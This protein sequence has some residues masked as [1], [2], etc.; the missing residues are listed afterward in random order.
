MPSSFLRSLVWAPTIAL[1]WLWGLGFFYAI[2]VTLTYGW[3]G[4]IAFAV[5]NATGLFLFGWILNS[6]RREPEQILSKAG[7]QYTLLFL[8]CQIFAVA[9]TIFGFAS[10]LWIPLFGEHSGVVVALL[11]LLSCAVGHA[12]P[13]A[14][15]R[16]LH[17]AYL[18]LGVAAGLLALWALRAAPV[19]PPLPLA[20]FDARFYGLVLPTLVGFLLGPW[21]D[22]Q[23]WQRVVEIRRAG[24][25]AG[26]AY[27]AGALLFLGLLALN[28]ALAA[29]AGRG[30]V[31]ITADGLPAAQAA[32]ALAIRAAHLDLA[33]I[34]FTIWA[35][36]A[37][38]ST[39]DSAYCATRWLMS[40]ITTRSTAPLMAFVP[41]GLVSS[42]VSLMLA[43]GGIAI[44]MVS[45]DL[46]L[47]Y[48]MI[49]FATLLVGSAACLVCTAFG[50]TQRH[51][52]VLNLMIGLA[53]AIVFLAGYV[54]PV[55]VFLTLAPLI[56]LIGA[57]PLL[58][59]RLGWRAK[60]PPPEA[61]IEAG[62]TR[63]VATVHPMPRP[64]S[65]ASHG[66]DGEWFVL[67]MTPTYDDTN[68]VGNIY[69]ANYFR[70]VGKARELFFN[71]C[72]PDFDLSRTDFYILTR[73]FTHDFR[74][75]A[76]EFD[77]VTV[78]IKVAEHNRKFVTLAHEIHSDT[79]GLLGRGEQTLMFVDPRSYR[80]LDIPRV[81]LE[82][83][84]PYLPATSAYVARRA[85]ALAEGQTVRAIG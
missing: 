54:A 8:L 38:V 45:N 25:S 85:A 39:I 46:S 69:F 70:W 30:H 21:M 41:E 44:A 61:A 79:H 16:L 11:L 36:I 35:A 83:F 81:V 58:L 4:F 31:V 9:I 76:R 10:C 64:E 15:L 56:G 20:A 22:V 1:S 73:S 84:F 48:L 78:R 62:A 72:V 32:V 33:A 65:G 14:R 7:G 74:R 52:A 17:I 23:Q 59:E 60:A 75:E 51:D 27:G 40:G 55:P 19:T 34:G 26:I 37:V 42:P 28:A 3:L 24:A 80:P 82:G 5:P 18:P 53:A 67:R 12:V 77:P 49:P 63:E 2:H 43:A 66:F 57:V 68:S 71:I 47:I 29:A 50:V 13:L 6:P